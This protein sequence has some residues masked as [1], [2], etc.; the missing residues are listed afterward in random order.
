MLFIRS[1]LPLL[2]CVLLALG[3]AWWYADRYGK[4]YEASAVLVLRLPKFVERNDRDRDSIE[5]NDIPTILSSPV[6]IEKAINHKKLLLLPAFEG[7]E[8]VADEISSR[9]AVREV[10]PALATFEIRYR[11]T[12]P[13]SALAVVKGLVAE[14]EEIFG[15]GPKT[16]DE[17]TLVLIS[18][19]EDDLEGRLAVG[20]KTLADYQEAIAPILKAEAKPDAEVEAGFERDTKRMKQEIARDES[21]LAEVKRKSADLRREFEAREPTFAVVS[22]VGESAEVRTNDRSIFLTWGL[23]GAVLGSLLTIG[24]IASDRRESRADE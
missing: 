23:A 7:K 14:Y 21:L 24:K 12:D 1:I 11:S 9:L 8:K 3:G 15:N 18:R 5:Q 17:Q 19:A 20:R 10:D 2:I 13:T 6:L 16:A 22:M 4:E